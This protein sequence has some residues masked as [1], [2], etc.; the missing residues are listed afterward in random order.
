MST[1]T[2]LL[3]QDITDIM[4]KV[5]I[6]HKHT[7]YIPLTKY[8][9]VRIEKLSE[10]SRP[11]RIHRAW[12]EINQYPARNI[13]AARSLVVV[14][15]NPLQLQVGVSDIGTS[16]IDTV[17]IRY[18]LPE[19][20]YT[21]GRWKRGE[22]VSTHRYNIYLRAY[23]YRGKRLNS[24]LSQSGYHIGQPVSEGFHAFSQRRKKD[25]NFKMKA[26]E[27]STVRA[28]SNFVVF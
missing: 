20:P 4:R 23:A 18:H 27:T 15:V 22:R 26:T 11:D 5:F 9:V 2:G 14:D 12:L 24:P 7:K 8:E 17:L 25:V 21:R 3:L 1:E 13:F 6:P 16:G 10:R 19:L 28:V